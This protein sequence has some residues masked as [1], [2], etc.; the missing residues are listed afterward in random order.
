METYKS[1]D[2]IFA[3]YADKY[4]EANKEYKSALYTKQIAEI[5]LSDAVKKYNEGMQLSK[6]CHDLLK[7]AEN[8]IV[9]MMKDDK[10]VDFNE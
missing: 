8:V 4:L 5:E 3:L 7:D 10:L 1:K 9:K 2:A 6:H